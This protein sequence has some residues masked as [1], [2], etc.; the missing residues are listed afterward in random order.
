MKRFAL[1]TC[2][3]FALAAAGCEDTEDANA[4]IQQCLEDEYGADAAEEMM[5]DWELSCDESEDACRSCIDCVVDAECT[6]LLDGTCDDTCGEA[7]RAE[8][9]TDE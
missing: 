8:E 3:L 4:K 9:D 5:P 7:T 2:A 1:M 6:A